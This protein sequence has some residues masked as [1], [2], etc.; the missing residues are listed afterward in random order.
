MK[1]IKD[2]E[3]EDQPYRPHVSEKSK[4]LV[5]SRSITKISQMNESGYSN[6]TSKW[7]LLHQESRKKLDKKDY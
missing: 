1:A 7:D 4:R 5:M 2:F 6:N 3:Q